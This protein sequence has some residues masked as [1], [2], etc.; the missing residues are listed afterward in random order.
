MDAV[1]QLQ[2]ITHR[3]P[4]Q[5]ALMMAFLVIDDRIRQLPKKCRDELFELQKSLMNA[6]DDDERLEILQT[7][8]E[9]LDDKPANYLHL[10]DKDIQSPREG[11]EKW[12]AFISK[13]IKEER[14]QAGLTQKELAEKSG[15]PQPHI[16]RLESGL[17]SPTHLTVQKIA[18]ALKIGVVRLDP[19]A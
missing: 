12:V 18:K 4:S 8:M 11:L 2:K 10:K 1:Q 14:E 17:H 6:A 7:M 15:L 9:I 13:R 3:D 19:S 5:A 16:S